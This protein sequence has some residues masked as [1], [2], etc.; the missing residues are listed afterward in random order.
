[1]EASRTILVV[2]DI[3]MFRELGSLFLARSGRVITA[4]GGMQALEIARRE[5][6]DLVVS[7]LHMP[8]MDGE[9]LCR[10]IKAD[11]ELA[12]TPV[13]MIVG[14]EDAA[15][16]AR[17]VRAG[18]DDLL[19][20]PLSRLALIEVVNRFL[21]GEP[22]RGLPRIELSEPVRLS[23]GSS[24]SWGTVRN[25][26]RGG[27]FVETDRVFDPHTEVDLHF[28]LPETESE[29]APTAQVVWQ[30]GENGS[31]DSPAPPGMGMRFL[32]IDGTTARRL[33]EFVFEYSLRLLPTGPGGLS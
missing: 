29:I 19:P 2:D 28:Q 5:R 4:E 23:A 27:I 7:D 6:P 14:S 32:E 26:S 33:E 1:V 30:R 24:E 17:A 16:H 3:A 12:G 20:K 21:H 10:A 11:E 9:A 18:A 31:A 22:V 8:E 13:I 15:D 25:L